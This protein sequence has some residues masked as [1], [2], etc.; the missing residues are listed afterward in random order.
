[1]RVQSRIIKVTERDFPKTT[2]SHI[3]P[4]STPY[5]DN[6]L[7][8]TP[9]NILFFEIFSNHTHSHNRATASVRFCAHLLEA[10]LEVAFGGG[11]FLGIPVAQVFRLPLQRPFHLLAP[12][13][14]RLGRLAKWS[15][16]VW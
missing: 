10:L 13:R 7:S 2:F 3:A 9:D 8:Y 5:G 11:R 1:M 4:D 15:A 14:V 16:Y 12:V 6:N